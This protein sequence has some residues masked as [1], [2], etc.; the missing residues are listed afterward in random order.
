[1]SSVYSLLIGSS[2]ICSSL[3]GITDS[4]VGREGVVEGAEGVV[5]GLVES[6][7]FRV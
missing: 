4:V 6:T 7:P 2:Q 5:R 3:E 1:M